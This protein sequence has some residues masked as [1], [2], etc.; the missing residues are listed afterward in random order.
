MAECTTAVTCLFPPVQCVDA[1]VTPEAMTW[2]SVSSRAREH[3]LVAVGLEK[4][5]QRCVACIDPLMGGAP[6][7]SISGGHTHPLVTQVLWSPRNSFVLLSAGSVALLR[8]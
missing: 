4:S 8:L 6:S 1:V 2:A 5:G 7:L 3:G